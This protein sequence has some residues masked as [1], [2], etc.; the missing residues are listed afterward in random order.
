MEGLEALSSEVGKEMENV[1]GEGL[2][3]S[4]SPHEQQAAAKKNDAQLHK[5]AKEA[6]DP[7]AADVSPSWSE[8]PSP[9]SPSCSLSSPIS[10]TL[11]PVHS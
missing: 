2:G 1:Q 9:S 8:F 3:L 10:S 6:A 4:E 7:A 5:E 11:P